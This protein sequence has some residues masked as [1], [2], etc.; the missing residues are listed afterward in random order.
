MVWRGRRFHFEFPRPTLV[1]GV[2]NVTPDSFYEAGRRPDVEEAVALGV[3]MAS[4]GADIL[5]VGGESTRPGAAPVNQDEELRRVLPVVE[6]LVAESG[7]PVSVD[8][9]KPAVAEA[10]LGAGAAIINDVQAGRT[11]REM[12]EVVAGAGA[13]YIAMHMKGE[14]ATMQDHPVYGDVVGEVRDFLADRLARLSAAGIP[15]H[16]VALDPGIGFGKSVFHNLGLL[17]RW[18]SFK[19]LE[20]PLV[21]GI[22]RKSLIGKVT[23]AGAG[24]RLPGSLA[25]GLWA[26]Q[27]GACVVRVHDPGPWVQ[28]LRMQEAIIAAGAP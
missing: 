4:E 27:H 13:G 12:W 9:R 18:A 3:R 6:R 1:M 22:S 26:V 14:P 5:D 19:S 8:T 7:R 24:E 16:Q 25:C 2:V 23:G 21:A 10:A 15:G 11:G 17:A 28:A 20:R